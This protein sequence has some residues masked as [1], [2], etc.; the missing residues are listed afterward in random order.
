MDDIPVLT[1]KPSP[2]AF[3]SCIAGIIFPGS[4]AY[5]LIGS[6]IID[7]QPVSNSLWFVG[8]FF[9]VFTIGSFITLLTIRTFELTRKKL[10]IKTPL[11]LFNR[12][13]V[14]HKIKEITERPFKVES[15]SRGNKTLIHTGL[16][17]TILQI[18]GK[19][20]TIDTFSTRNYKELIKQL[21]HLYCLK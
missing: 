7:R 17:A 8:G 4:I 6:K 19:K 3:I 12:T 9:L 1:A 13:I 2:I 10:V 16:K 5:Y 20:I 11:S 14:L 21:K 15:S 18:N